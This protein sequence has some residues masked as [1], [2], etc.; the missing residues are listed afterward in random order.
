MIERLRVQIPAG[1]V[2]EFSS[3]ELT[4][5]A[6]SL[7]GVPS[8][9]VLPQW[10]VKGT[11]HSATSADGRLHQQTHT[12]LIQQSQSGLTMLLSRHSVRTYQDTSSHATHLETLSQ[13]SQLAEP[14]WTYSSLKSGISMSL[15]VS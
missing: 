14:L 11:G 5:W 12:P 2:G 1:A 13:S 3:P 15:C 4:L 10:H 7:F 9:S 6:D 8:I